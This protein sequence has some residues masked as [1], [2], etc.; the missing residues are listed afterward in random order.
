M[1]GRPRYYYQGGV[2]GGRPE[3]GREQG[4]GVGG[5]LAKWWLPALFHFAGLLGGEEKR[6]KLLCSVVRPSVPRAEPLITT[7]STRQ[8]TRSTFYL[9]RG[10]NFAVLK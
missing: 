8:G 10:A 5:G 3:P 7:L 6:E 1:D 2:F 4:Q 9:L